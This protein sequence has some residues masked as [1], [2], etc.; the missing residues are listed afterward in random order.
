MPE[1]ISYRGENVVKHI[2]ARLVPPDAR[3]PDSVCELLLTERH[4]Y[5]LEDNYDGT[6]TEHFNLHLGQIDKMEKVYYDDKATTYTADSPLVNLSAILSGFVT[7]LILWAGAEPVQP[8]RTAY[9][10]ITYRNGTSGKSL[11]HFTSYGSGVDG[12]VKA[13]KKKQAALN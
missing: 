5:V 2:N 9:L 13:L 8:K 11:L 4:F 3:Y 12:F 10:E 7:A 6:Y 1:L